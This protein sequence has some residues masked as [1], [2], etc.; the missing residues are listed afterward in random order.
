MI[1][2]TGTLDGVNPAADQAMKRSA[3]AVATKKAGLDSLKRELQRGLDELGSATSNAQDTIKNRDK[4][5]GEHDGEVRELARLGDV[6]GS[7]VKRLRANYG[8]LRSGVIAAP[9]QVIA[10]TSNDY[11]ATRAALRTA[12]IEQGLSEAYLKGLRA[13]VEGGGP[14]T[15][16]SVCRRGLQGT[17]TVLTLPLVPVIWLREKGFGTLQLVPEMWEILIRGEERV[18]RLTRNLAKVERSVNKVTKETE[19]LRHLLRTCIDNAGREAARAPQV[20]ATTPLPT[21]DSA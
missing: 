19:Y 13:Q 6:L 12:E 21:G 10:Q 3:D 17:T 18:N 11:D 5:I 15:T 8:N 9:N 20:A 1:R 14:G 2:N 7:D 4:L 16:P